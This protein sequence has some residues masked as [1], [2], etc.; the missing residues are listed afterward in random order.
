MTEELK[1]LRPVVKGIAAKLMRRLSLPA[2]ITRDELEAA[3]L[4]GAWEAVQRFDGRGTLEGFAGTRIRGAMLDWLRTTHPLGR[5]KKRETVSFVGLDENV[6]LGETCDGPEVEATRLSEAA[7][8]L[9]A[10]TP[11]ERRLAKKVLAGEQLKAIAVA[12]GVDP[13]RITQ[14]LNGAIA[15]M[16]KGHSKIP[17]PFD[18][19][20][21]KVVVGEKVPRTQAPRGKIAELLARI[22]PRGSVRL[23]AGIADSLCRAMRERKI[24]YARR[25]LPGGLVHITRE[26]SPEQLGE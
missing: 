21:V 4:V 15:R 18:P 9:R 5:N 26:P 16:E 2:S 23:E 25:K 20:A 17:D 14:R 10:L 7:H 3:G 13:T 19:K 8:R 11:D 1:R 12:E 22:P 24:R 6:E